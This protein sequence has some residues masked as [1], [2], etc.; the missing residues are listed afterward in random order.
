LEKGQGPK[1]KPKRTRKKT[2]EGKQMRELTVC[3][4][5]IKVVNKKKGGQNASD[6]KG[7]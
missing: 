5:A 4:G 7:S 6:E 1:T 2:R 3:A